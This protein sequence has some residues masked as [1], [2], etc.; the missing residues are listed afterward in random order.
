M[1]N[2]EVSL[3]KTITWTKKIKKGEANVEKACVEFGM[4]TRN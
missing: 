4:N 2:P 3:K 1:K